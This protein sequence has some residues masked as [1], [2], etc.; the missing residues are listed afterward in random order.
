MQACGIA[1]DKLYRTYAVEPASVAEAVG[2]HAILVSKQCV[3]AH[4]NAIGAGRGEYMGTLIVARQ[5][6][7]IVGHTLRYTVGRDIEL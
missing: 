5:Q 2:G 6:T 4:A 1:I 3:V 7:G